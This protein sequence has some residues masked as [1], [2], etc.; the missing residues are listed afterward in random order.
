MA[1]FLILAL[2]L[3]CSGA[4]AQTDPLR[5]PA[6]LIGGGARTAAP[7]DTLRLQSVLISGKH[8]EAIIN[9]RLL[10]IGQSINGYRL[11]A[12]D[13]RSARLAGPSGTVVLQLLPVKIQPR[14]AAASRPATRQP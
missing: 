3:A 5:P 8:R 6:G 14:A 10:G 1:R 7:D 2:C 13:E 11:L 12:L 4:M 9:G